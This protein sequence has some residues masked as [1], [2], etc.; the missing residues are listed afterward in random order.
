[1]IEILLLSLLGIGLTALAVDRWTGDD[2]EGERPDDRPDETP[3]DGAGGEG[4]TDGDDTLALG[5][6]ATLLAG[7]GDDRVTG[8]GALGSVSVDGGRGDDVLRLEDATADPA[9]LRGGNGDDELTFDGGD[10]SRGLLDGGAGHDRLDA[11]ESQGVFLIG[12]GGEDLLDITRTTPDAVG[13]TADGGHG[14]DTIRASAVL[15]AGNAGATLTGGEGAD[16]F[17]IGVEVEAVTDPGDAVLVDHGTVL[18]VADFTPG[19]DVLAISPEASF[20]GGPPRALVNVALEEGEADGAPFTTL[21]LFYETGVAGVLQTGTIRLDG[22][23]GLTLDDIELDLTDAP[24]DIALSPGAP[25]GMAPGAIGGEGDDTVTGASLGVGGI[26]ETRGGGD[27]IDVDHVDVHGGAGDDVIDA[28]GYSIV[29]EGGDGDDVITGDFYAGDAYGGAG[30]DTISFEDANGFEVTRADGGAGDDTLEVTVEYNRIPGV[31][32]ALVGGGGA[33][34]FVVAVEGSTQFDSNGYPTSE[35][36]IIL[37][38]IDFAPGED[39]LV[40]EAEPDVVVTL[41]EQGDDTLVVL[42]GASGSTNAIHL[43]GTTG[44]SAGDIVLLDRAE[45]A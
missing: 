3:D 45:A 2:D 6:D 43:A 12:G 5:F 28:S 1:M 39:V 42:T 26:V 34:L 4:P 14:D 17:E 21:T 13:S 31:P 18:T 41:T 23:R 30:N 35:Q 24:Q 33:D 36:E 25:G 7:D 22:V 16:R 11:G 32:S 44:L 38:I 8:T 20:D 10:V 27:R 29:V 37:N 19:E 9:F 15:A 40:I